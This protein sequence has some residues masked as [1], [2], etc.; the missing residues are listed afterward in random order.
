MMLLLIFVISL[1]GDV[2]RKLSQMILDKKFHGNFHEQVRYFT[3]HRCSES[4]QCAVIDIYFFFMTML[5][6]F[7][8]KVKVS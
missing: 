2:E 7:S 5:Q 1:Q 6:E 3:L 8:T 4:L